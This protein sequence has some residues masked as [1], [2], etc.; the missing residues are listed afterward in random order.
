MIKPEI[1][2]WP[3]IPNHRLIAPVN[4]QSEQHAIHRFIFDK[5]QSIARQERAPH[6]IHGGDLL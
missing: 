4:K 5:L 2:N 3:N 1:D 6:W